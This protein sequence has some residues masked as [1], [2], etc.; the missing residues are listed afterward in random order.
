MK[1]FLLATVF[2]ISASAVATA[3]ENSPTMNRL[4]IQFGPN[5]AAAKQQ[6]ISQCN[7]GAANCKINCPVSLGG[8]VAGCNNAQF[9]CLR[10]CESIR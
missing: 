3:Q 5:P 6:C 8:C 9:S 2:V 7:Q 1:K 10:Q 4:L